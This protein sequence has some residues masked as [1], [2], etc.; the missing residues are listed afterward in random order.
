MERARARIEIAG[1]GKKMFLIEAVAHPKVLP[2]LYLPFPPHRDVPHEAADV[3]RA[4]ASSAVAE[5]IHP[6]PVARGYPS[7]R[8]CIVNECLIVA[9]WQGFLRF[10]ASDISF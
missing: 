3:C 6:V 5:G 10:S 2:L 1:K 7:V 8:H 9:L 4:V